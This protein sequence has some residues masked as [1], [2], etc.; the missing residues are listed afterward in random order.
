MGFDEGGVHEVVRIRSREVGGVGHAGGGGRL[1][2]AALEVRGGV[3]PRPG[4]E[5]E[6]VRIVSFLGKHTK[7]VSHLDP[8]GSRS[9]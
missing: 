1:G 7:R 4:L 9:R 6:E 8:Q 2:D 5:V 3:V